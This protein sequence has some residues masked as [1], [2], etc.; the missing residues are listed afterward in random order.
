VRQDR[1]VAKGLL[2]IPLLGPLRGRAGLRFDW[3]DT[4]R[5]KIVAALQPYGAGRVALGSGEIGIALDTRAGKLTEER[6]F[7]LL[8]NVR[9]APA[10][11]DNDFAFTKFRGEASSLFGGHV[12]TDLLLE[13]RVAGEKN[14]G[15]YPFFDAAFLGGAAFVSPADLSAPFGGAVLRGFDLNRFAGDSSLAGNAELRIALGKAN[16]FLPLRYG[17]SMLGDTGRVF[18]STESSSRWH[19]GLGG[20]LWLA[21]YATAPGAVISSAINAT[22]VRSEERTS[23]YFSSGFGL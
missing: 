12:F 1:V 18:V 23:F 15:R 13:L 2:E 16:L 5:E 19:Y 6:G 3:V 22:V 9:H 7:R 14:W 8:A 4:R 20:G 11:L 10:I 17:V 21:L